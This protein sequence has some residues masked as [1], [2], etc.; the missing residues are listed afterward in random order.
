MY[1]HR[2]KP[3]DRAKA[4]C[5][6]ARPRGRMK[7][8]ARRARCVQEPQEGRSPA[9]ERESKVRQSPPERPHAKE[10]NTPPRRAT[11]E[12]EDSYASDIV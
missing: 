6:M 1:T 2:A 7:G 8:E 12:K 5:G 4:R 3:R 11:R 10:Y 9:T